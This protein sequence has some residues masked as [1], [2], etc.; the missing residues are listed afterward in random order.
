MVLTFPSSSK[1]SVIFQT[2]P[3]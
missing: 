2:L 3:L 1:G